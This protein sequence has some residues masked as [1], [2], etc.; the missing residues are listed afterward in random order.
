MKQQTNKQNVKQKE[1]NAINVNCNFY[2][3]NLKPAAHPMNSNK[4]NVF[5]DY[6][7]FSPVWQKQK[8]NNIKKKT[9]RNKK[10]IK[11]HVFL[12]LSGCSCNTSFL[13]FRN[14]HQHHAE[15]R[16]IKTIQYS[17][18]E[19]TS[20]QFPQVFSCLALPIRDGAICYQLP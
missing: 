14:Y 18:T 12:H 19:A 17:T 16:S 9:K 1:K 2:R 11:H 4:G 20:R 6:I 15:G 3:E 5:M 7:P 8:Q 10:E 13:R